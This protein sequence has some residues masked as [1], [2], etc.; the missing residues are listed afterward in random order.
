MQTV[1]FLKLRYLLKLCNV[2]VGYIIHILDTVKELVA[3][4]YDHQLVIPD[5]S[6]LLEL[7]CRTYAQI[8]FYRASVGPAE[9][10]RLIFPVTGICI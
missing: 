6:F 9:Y 1:T 2:T 3:V 7:H 5:E 10:H 8:I 4:L